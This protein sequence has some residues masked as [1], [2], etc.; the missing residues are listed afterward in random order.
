[1]RSRVI[2]LIAGKEILSTL[3][4]RRALVSN[5]LI[6]LLTL[7][8]IML[9]LPLLLGG[10][11]E[12]EAVS[13]TSVAASG[14]QELPAGLADFL[15]EQK[16]RLEENFDPEAA[17][18]SGEVQTG[19]IVPPGFGARLAAGQETGLTL[20]TRSGNMNSELASAKLRSAI[21]AYQQQLVLDRLGREG[22]NPAILTPF[23]VAV[24]DASSE[25]ERSSGMLGWLIP[26]FI[27][28]WALAGG[29]M[30]AIDA[31]AGEK[32]RGTL[33]SLLVAPV[34]RS[35]VVIGK[36]LATVVFG[37]TA[38]LMAI[39][40]Y[41]LGSLLTRMLVLPR[42]GDEGGEMA[43]MLGGV[44]NISLL[45][46]LELLVS[47]VLLAGLIS[48]LLIS[49]ALFA[50]SFKEAQSYLAPLSFLMIIPAIGLQ[51]RDFLDVGYGIYLVPLLNALL[52][53][54]DI[55]RGSADATAI[56]LTWGS[57]AV[58]IIVLL[59]FAYRS[60][61]REDVIFRS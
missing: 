19:L 13:L 49:I 56:A 44:L 60:F 12:R 8:L 51:F 27:A 58:S 48:A 15:L 7:P 31:T 24:R 35:E 11:F 57:L 9:G 45:G 61:Q 36:W 5:L 53:M 43:G 25:Q 54:F 26:F 22:I 14:T 28:I 46:T 20:L 4:D 50:R 55:V 2:S 1:M 39:G 3:R 47:A 37:L 59:L 23:G 42:L 33:E 40:G 52:V 10:L 16:L 34:R 30:T 18:R 32:E 29:Q 21:G 17:V 38:T 41:L 6:P